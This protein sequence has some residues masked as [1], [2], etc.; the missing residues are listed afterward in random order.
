M[1]LEFNGRPTS[2]LGPSMLS[3]VMVFGNLAVKTKSEGEYLSQRQS[4]Q[5]NAKLIALLKSRLLYFLKII[6]DKMTIQQHFFE[7]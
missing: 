7:F 4:L 2:F 6:L 5:L 3:W 1:D